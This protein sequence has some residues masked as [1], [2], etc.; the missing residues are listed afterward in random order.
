MQVIKSK[1][2]YTIYKIDNVVNGKVYIGCTINYN[3][4]VSDHKGKLRK[5]IHPNLELQNDYNKYGEVAFRFSIL[6]TT[7]DKVWE[8]WYTMMYFGSGK[9]YNEK[10]INKF[11]D[12]K[13][14]NQK[15]VT[16]LTTQIKYKSSSEASKLTGCNNG[17][18][19]K[20]CQFKYNYT[21][22]KQGNKHRFVYSDY[23][24]E[25]VELLPEATDQEY[26]IYLLSK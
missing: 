14:T 3:K 1:P 23:L 17:N 20:C 24:Q 11:I 10:A 4:R 18:V 12:K 15:A 7:D 6:T 2:L 25:H 21:T 13:S 8:W 26:L 9:L 22:D 5:N 16:D 19:I